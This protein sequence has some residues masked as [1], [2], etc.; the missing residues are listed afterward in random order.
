MDF[1]SLA[2]S[3]SMSIIFDFNKQLEVGDTGEEKF[4]SF[5]KDLHPKKSKDRRFDFHIDGEKTVELKTDTYPIDNT[6]N[7]FME[8]F[9]NIDEAKLGGP[10]RALQDEVD[11]FVYFFIKNKTFFWFETVSLCKMIDGLI[12]QHGLKPREIKNRSWTAMGYA[13]PR[14][15]LETILYRKDTF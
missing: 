1:I 11:Y 6:P 12:A 14:N 13:I 4:L 15:E 9:G 3:F 5:Y 7:F 8:M 2:I 10:W